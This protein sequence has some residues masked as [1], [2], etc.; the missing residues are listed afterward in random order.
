MDGIG[1]GRN[2]S[3]LFFAPLLLL[4]C[5]PSLLFSFFYSLFCSHLTFFFRFQFRSYLFFL[6]PFLPLTL[7]KPF[8]Q[9]H[10][11]LHA[12]ENVLLHFCNFRFPTNWYSF[13]SLSPFPLCFLRFLI[14]PM[15]LPSLLEF[16]TPPI[17]VLA[18][19]DCQFELVS[20]NELTALRLIARKFVILV[21]GVLNCELG[22]W[23]GGFVFRLGWVC[24]CIMRRVLKMDCV[25]FRNGWEFQLFCCKLWSFFLLFRWLCLCFYFLYQL[26]QAF[27]DVYLQVNRVEWQFLGLWLC[28]RWRVRLF[29]CCCW[30]SLPLIQSGFECRW[31]FD[32]AEWVVFIEEALLLSL[33]LLCWFIFLKS[34]EHSR[35]TKRIEFCSWVINLGGGDK[36]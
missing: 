26:L 22:F 30:L 34:F 7:T 15:C 16:R 4:P 6:F 3:G 19:S 2:W 23:I 10:L 8:H 25:E 9:L 29:D 21:F 13:P 31:F 35:Q 12:E 33:L 17:R 24:G 36:W 14:L 18:L 32:V 27:G 28:C 20:N 5:L 1:I 11:L